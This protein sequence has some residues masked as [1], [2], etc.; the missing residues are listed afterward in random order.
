MQIVENGTMVPENKT[1]LRMIW[2]SKVL[3]WPKVSTPNF[4]P[5]LWSNSSFLKYSVWTRDRVCT[6][7]EGIFIISR[8][9]VFEDTLGATANV[10][11]MWFWSEPSSSSCLSFKWRLFYFR[12][13]FHIKGRG[14]SRTERETVIVL[15]LHNS[16]LLLEIL[17][18]WI[19]FCLLLPSSFAVV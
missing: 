2:A 7:A 15:R 11:S 8:R 17:Y 1:L 13:P 18:V 5:L 19:G 12:S 3:Q 10:V 16:N 9:L 4:N 6:C 14:L